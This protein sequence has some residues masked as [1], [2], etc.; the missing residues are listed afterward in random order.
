MSP[1]RAVVL[2]EPATEASSFHPNN[3]IETRV[4]F[5]VALEDL[6]TDDVFFQLI[7]FA[8]QRLLHNV[9]KKFA[10]AARAS[11]S[12]RGQDAVELGTN[13]RLGNRC[14]LPSIS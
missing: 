13:V 7:G 5:V 3:R 11:K 12:F 2:V 9:A 6:E 1:V 8:G 14:H 4:V 10:E